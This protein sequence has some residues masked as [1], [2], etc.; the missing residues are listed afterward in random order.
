MRPAAW[1]AMKTIQAFAAAA[2]VA[3]LQWMGGTVVEGLQPSSRCNTF[4]WAAPTAE[5]LSLHAV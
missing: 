4:T 5:E 3:Y 1:L 2:H